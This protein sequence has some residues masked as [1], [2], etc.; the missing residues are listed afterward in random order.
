MERMEEG[1]ATRRTEGKVFE[2]VHSLCDPTLRVAKRIHAHA[3]RS[4]QHVLAH[5]VTLFESTD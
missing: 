1:Q 3:A 5:K 2:L 4:V